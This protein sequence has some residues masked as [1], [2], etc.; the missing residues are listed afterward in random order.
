VKTCTSVQAWTP[1]W[2]A[3]QQFLAPRRLF[4]HAHNALDQKRH[5]ALEMLARLN[6]IEQGFAFG[7][8]GNIF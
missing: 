8:L 1:K 4:A 6:H 3:D 5:P 7:G 2:V